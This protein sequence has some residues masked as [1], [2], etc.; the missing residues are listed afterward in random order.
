MKQ[1]RADPASSE[2]LRAR[3]KRETRL[4]IAEVGLRLFLENGYDATTLDSIAAAAGIS[5]RTIFSY[6]KSKDDLVLT[7]QAAA[8]DDMLRELLTV[9]PEIPPLEAICSQLVRYLAPYESEQV[10]ASDR[11]MRASE[12]L[13]ARKQ[14][15]YAAQEEALFATLCQ[16]WPDPAQRLRLRIVAMVAMGALRLALESWGTDQDGRTAASFLE[17]IFAQLAPDRW[18]AD[19]P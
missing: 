11:L 12:T 14:A 3:K 15:T 16:V 17:E 18:T 7:L 6:F 8:W 10:R 5:R 1:G 4:H 2:G 9:S 13:K 19:A